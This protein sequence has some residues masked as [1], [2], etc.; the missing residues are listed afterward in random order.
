MIEIVSDGL[1][2]EIERCFLDSETSIRIVS[3]FLSCKMAELLCSIHELKKDI[4]CA[5][6]TR[7]YMKDLVEGANSL[8]AL[9]M[10]VENG[11]EVYA[12]QALHAKVYLFDDSEV[13]IGSA[14]FTWSGLN[15]NCELSIIT[16]DTNILTKASAFYDSLIEY[17]KNNNGQVTKELLDTVRTDYDKAYK[18][19]QKDFG[20]VSS[21]M[22]GA[23]RKRGGNIIKSDW[24]IDDIKI[25]D[26]D[27]V[28]DLL[29]GSQKKTTF[30]HNIWAKFE[31]R[32]DNRQPGNE[33]PTLS[34]VEIDGSRKYI[35]NFRH[36]PNSI[37]SGDQLYIVSLT[38][39]ENGKPTTRIVGRGKGNF[40]P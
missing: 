3:P 15:K 13:I 4:E 20:F 22:Y 8:D 31:G 37:Q 36:R 25:E 6:I 2:D 26:K 27:P 29:S 18:E 23:E 1:K 5:M 7:I 34:E 9:T 30:R 40:L 19:R 12:L 35:I 10:L 33:K 39:D 21:K 11:I 16:D 28:F 32:A 17:C 38:T 24:K 14:N